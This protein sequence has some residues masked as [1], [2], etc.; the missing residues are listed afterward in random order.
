MKG[1]ESAQIRMAGPQQTPTRI[2]NRSRWPAPSSTEAV[3]ALLSLAG[4]QSGARLNV[5]VAPPTGTR[6]CS[7]MTPSSGAG[8]RLVAAPGQSASLYSSVLYPSSGP[9]M[10]TAITERGGASPRLCVSPSRA[11]FNWRSGNVALPWNCVT[12]S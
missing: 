1:R 12:S 5:L 11:F 3:V 6:S 4:L 8:H 9:M 2:C 7:A 10:V